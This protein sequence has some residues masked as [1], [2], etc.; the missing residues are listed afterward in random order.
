LF[1]TL[2]AALKTLLHRYLGQDD[3]RVATNVANRHRAGTERLIGP[4]VNTMILRTDLGGDPSPR[5]VMRRVR[6][7]TLAAFAHQDLPFE[8]LAESFERDCGLKPAVLTSVMFLLQN[9]S[10][11][12]T[13]S[14]GQILSFEEV[15]PSILLPLLT[16]TTFDISLTLREVSD[17]LA[18]TCVYKPSLFD[19][20]TIDYVLR[21]FQEVL[22]AIVTQP[23][24]PISAIRVFLNEKASKPLVLH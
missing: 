15:D 10:L 13:S 3:V 17:G 7:T 12:P 9:A 20:A 8:E 22:G 23:E 21:D 2:I 16:T 18:G 11:R 4:L 1:M 19:A 5:E 6:A 24:R 14:F